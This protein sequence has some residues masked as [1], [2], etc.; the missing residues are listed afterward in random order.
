MAAISAWPNASRLPQ[1][2]TLATQ[3]R[4]S[5]GVPSWNLRLSRSVS[6]QVFP[7]ASVVNPSTICGCALNAPS[8]PNS[9][10]NT[11]KPWLREM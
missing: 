6:R 4:A 1:R 8:C 2:P 3:S 9:V 5:T 11:T 10:S 7:S